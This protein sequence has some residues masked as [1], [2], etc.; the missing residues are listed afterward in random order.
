MKQAKVDLQRRSEYSVHPSFSLSHLSNYSLSTL[1]RTRNNNPLTFIECLQILKKIF[2][3]PF[4]FPNSKVKIKIVLL[5]FK[6]I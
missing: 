5:L 2:H 4:T 6:Y 1:I 3:T